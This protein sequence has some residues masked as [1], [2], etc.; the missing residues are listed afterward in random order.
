MLTTL[1]EDVEVY[2]QND[3][4]RQGIVLYFDSFLRRSKL[5]LELANIEVNSE[6]QD[7][8]N[9]SDAEKRALEYD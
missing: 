3:G 1:A 7:C 9:A 5:S 8:L 2:V 4:L 6:A